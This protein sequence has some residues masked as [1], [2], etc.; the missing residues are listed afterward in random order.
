M[1]FKTPVL[2]Y[3]ITIYMKLDSI[4]LYLDY[5]HASP[6]DNLTVIPSSVIYEKTNIEIT[7]LRIFT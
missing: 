5:T 7:N 4:I 2:F 3:K 6:K 1:D